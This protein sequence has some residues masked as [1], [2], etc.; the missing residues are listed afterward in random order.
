MNNKFLPISIDDLKERGW[1]RLDIILITG[2]AYVD[3]PSYGAAVISRLLEDAGFKVGIIAQPNWK[4]L[5]DFLRLDRPRLFFGI[6][7]GNLDSILSNYTPSKRPRKSDDYSPGGKPGMR[8]NRATIA[9]VNKVKEAFPDIPVVLGGIEASL[10]RLAHYDYW[11][12]EVRHSILV[13]AKADI[14][15]YGMGEKQILEI[16]KRLDQEE[17]IEDLNNIRGT[18]VVRKNIDW[19]KDYIEIFSFE[20]VKTNQDKFNEAFRVFYLESDPFRGKTIVQRDGSRFVIQFS[21]ALPLTK[22]E[23]D[24][25]YLLPYVRKPHFIYDQEGKIP[26]FETVKFSVT[27]HRG[28]CG[29]CCFCSLSVHQGRIIQSRSLESILKEITIITQEKNFKGTITDIGGPTANLYQ[30]KCQCWEKDGTCRKK[31]CLFPERCKNLKLGYK[32]SLSLWQE[33]RNISTIK[34]LFISSG[35]RYDLLVSNH[36]EEYLNTLCKYHIS[37]QLK[38]ASEHTVDSILRLMNKPSFKVYERFGEK[39]KEIN[40]RLNKKQYLVNYFISSHPGS[41]LDQALEI[42]LY[43]KKKHIHP[44]QIQDFIPLP[45]TIS[46]CMYYTKKHP[47]TGEKVYVAKEIKEKM[48]QRALIQYYQPKNKRLVL[49]ALKNLNKLNLQKVFFP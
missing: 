16:A 11:S 40:K 17:R 33:V 34:H 47:L 44:E 28:C 32:E 26:G 36:S 45:L 30:A 48:M 18:V 43:L 38:I 37:G 25:I 9:Y 46:G 22:E 19:L 15:V 10:R 2:D 3:H 41:N 7:A 20:E 27:S 4:S 35:L 49:K 12:D 24:H 13:D 1:K 5:D 42:A 39:F 6:T 23:L 21:P 8:P 31:R 14:L 29:E